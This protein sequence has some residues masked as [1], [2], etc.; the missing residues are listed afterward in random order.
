M[1]VT[2]PIVFFGT[3]TYADGRPE[4]GSITIAPQL[5]AADLADPAKIITARGITTEL[6]DDGHFEVTLNASDSPGWYAGGDMPYVV[7]ERLSGGRRTYYILAMEPGPIDLAEVQIDGVGSPSAPPIQSIVATPGPQG[8]QGVPGQ[9]GGPIGP[10]GEKGDTGAQGDVGQTGAQGPIGET[11]AKGDKGDKGSTGIQGLTGP[12]GT[13]G[14]NGTNGAKGDTGAQG[15]IGPT[16][17]K[18]DKGDKGDTGATGAPGT[19][20]PSTYT[21]AD[22]TITGWTPLTAYSPCRVYRVGPMVTLQVAV[23]G[24]TPST[25]II[26]VIPLGYR[27]AMEFNYAGSASGNVAC[28]FKVNL[29]GA[30]MLIAGSTSWNDMIVTYITNDAAP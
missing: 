8:P 10:Q 3:Y 2:T 30:I 29:A 1:A 4:V 13:N 20:A 12:P 21:Y 25:D 28:R 15:S 22:L 19:P 5:T 11:G 17:A 9:P 26:G 6:D 27:P 18:G 23:T 7:T 16:G 14:T 24:G